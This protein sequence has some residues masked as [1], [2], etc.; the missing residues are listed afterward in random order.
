MWRRGVRGVAADDDTAA[1]PRP[2][3]QDRLDRAID[4]VGVL[5]ERRRDFGDVAAVLLQPLLQ[6][7]RIVLASEHGV[8]RFRTD[9]EDVH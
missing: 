8:G 5:I 1:K 4:D 6:Q 9:M 3:H 7:A 2:R